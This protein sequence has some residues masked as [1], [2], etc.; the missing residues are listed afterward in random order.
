MSVLVRIDIDSGFTELFFPDQESGRAWTAK[1]P[2]TPAGQSLG[3]LAGHD[4]TGGPDT[5]DHPSLDLVRRSR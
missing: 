5:S 3:L 2:S 1:F 4:S